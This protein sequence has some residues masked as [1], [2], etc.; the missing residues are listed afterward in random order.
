MGEP[1]LSRY[2]RHNTERAREQQAT[3][4]RELERDDIT[5]DECLQI[6]RDSIRLTEQLEQDHRDLLSGKLSPWPQSEASP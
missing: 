2:L 6:A 3:M 1:L 5:A 4:L